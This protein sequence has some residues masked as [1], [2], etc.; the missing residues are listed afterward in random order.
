MLPYY[1]GDYEPKQNN[2]DFESVWEIL[3]KKDF[4]MVV[5]RRFEMVDNMMECKP[6]MKNEIIPENQ[7]IILCQ[8]K[9]N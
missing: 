9:R 8:L 3:M 4:K 5:K 6:Y 7:E 2:I 1:E